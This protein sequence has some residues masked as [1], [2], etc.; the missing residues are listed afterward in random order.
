VRAGHVAAARPPDEVLRLSA[1]TPLR[2]GPWPGLD[3][4]IFVRLARVGLPL[5]ASGLFFVGIYLGL[6]GTVTAAGGDAAQAGLGLGLR[7]EQVAWMLTN[8]F[9]L[10]AS[11]LV[12][13][14]LG[15]GRPDEA[16]SAAWRA[17]WLASAGCLLWSL[18]LAF[19]PEI[20]AGFF[21]PGEADAAARAHAVAYYRLVA[22]CLV[23]QCWEGV[24]DSAFAGAGLTIPPMVVSMALTGLRI[25]LAHAAV[26]G[27]GWGVTG[28]WIVIV[29]TAAL[30]GI[31]VAI[32]F[33]LGTWKHRTV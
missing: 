10:A 27:L 17:N 28:I 15:A 1:D 26:F 2:P 7:G 13:R 19:A 33:S 31:V 5:T 21:L 3:L 24:L 29:A 14:R 8:G 6:S 23:P 25:P 16:A 22:L 9:C 20:V 18:A 30:R 12:A 4:S 11:S 32:W